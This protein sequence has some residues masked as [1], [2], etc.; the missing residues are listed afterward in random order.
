MWCDSSAGTTVTR[1]RI[2]DGPVLTLNRVQATAALT[3][4]SL[5]TAQADT[6]H[7][8]YDDLDIGVDLADAPR[9][10]HHVESL[11][12]SA[13][14][15]HN[16]ATSGDFD[17]FTGTAFS[18]ATTNGW[19]FFAHRPLQNANTA[20]QVIRQDLGGITD[21]M[22]FA[23]E[24]LA[25]GV[26]IPEAIRAIAVLQEGNTGNSNAEIRLLL[27]D[28]T[29]VLTE[30]SIS[31]VNDT[32]AISDV[33][34]TFF[35]R[36]T[37]PPSGGWDRTKVNGLKVRIGY[38]DNAPDVNFID[39]ML[40]V[41]L[42]DITYATPSK[43]SA[44]GAAIP[45]PSIPRGA[46]PTPDSI[47]AI[48]AIATP[49][50]R[51]TATATPTKV[52]ALA[53]V[54][55][56]TVLAGT[57]TNVFPAKVSAVAAVRTPN[58]TTGAA[59]LDHYS[60]GYGQGYE[61]IEEEVV[62]PPVVVRIPSTTPDLRLRVDW[63]HD[64][65]PVDGRMPE[66]RWTD[67]S[68]MLKAPEGASI[69][70]GRQRE[71]DRNEAGQMTV[72][73]ADMDRLLDTDNFESP[74]Y[75][76]ITPDRRVRLESVTPWNSEAF[77]MASSQV[78][79]DDLVGGGH[80]FHY[81]PIF[82]GVI[83]SFEYSYPGPG[84]YSLVTLRCSDLLALMSRD[85]IGWFSGYANSWEQ[86]I[87]S[88]LNF[89]SYTGR[90]DGVSA[91]QTT[92]SPEL[93]DIPT[94]PTNADL[95]YDQNISING[96]MLSTLE[97]LATS[98]GGNFFIA[99]DGKPTFRPSSWL[100]RTADPGRRW[101]M[102][103]ERFHDVAMKVDETLIYNDI[104]ITNYDNTVQFQTTDPASQARHPGRPPLVIQTLITGIEG[105][106]LRAEGFLANYHDAT[107]V[108]T[109]LDLSNVV[110]DWEM[111]LGLELWD[112]IT[113]EVVLPNGDVI[114]Q[115]SLVQ[116]IEITT[117]NHRDW[118]P[119]LW[120]SVP[121]FG[122]LLDADN[123]SFEGPT[124][125]DWTA[126]SNSTVSAVTEKVQWR[127]FRRGESQIP[128]VAPIQPPR[129]VT[130]LQTVPIVAGVFTAISGYIPVMPRQMY[131][132]RASEQVVMTN[133][134][135]NYDLNAS[136]QAHLEIDWY[137]STLAYLSTDIGDEQTVYEHGTGGGPGSP[138]QHPAWVRLEVQ[139]R[140]PSGAAFARLRMSATAALTFQ[141]QLT[142]DVLFSRVV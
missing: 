26:G 10:G 91:G 17:S 126:E 110:D 59:S 129:G 77:T 104:T 102:D 139:K 90:A 120:V 32:E 94:Q 138:N 50:I 85:E 24:N 2:D 1:C 93:R 127:S 128:G 38:S 121:P 29:E 142:D 92:P 89:R 15:T 99:K 22:E 68:A 134:T 115:D 79:G 87:D 47:D 132:G 40:S 136:Q 41:S 83:D 70:R 124:V 73:V 122:N 71:L 7:A 49:F 20:N 14:G 46:G 43:V 113:L 137:D 21:Y 123:Q 96:D 63:E 80:T 5:G 58:I 8:Y 97:L 116:G 75:P 31:V 37:I 60:D 9:G 4:W 118:Q 100:E 45:T 119:I 84:K 106:T 78:G 44:P 81:S 95:D 52:S 101:A 141:G 54:P 109:M 88:V 103:A 16:I 112:R 130:A 39:F 67:I 64:L 133:L 65:N 86:A 61:T 57:F 114:T 135:T 55:T 3:A 35:K 19:T 69:K 125:G 72:T 42:T 48:A 12:V 25:S 11:I 56:P 30:G 107:K 34:T 108:V 140:A 82:D 18:N 76:G 53:A 111:V 28:N 13:D 23:I 74:Y 62:E 33:A 117:S 105:L 98:E 27:S 6:Y 36:M 131:L 66:P 51:R